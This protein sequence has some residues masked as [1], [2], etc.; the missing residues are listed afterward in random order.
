MNNLYFTY[1]FVFSSQQNDEHQALVK[2]PHQRHRENWPAG[3]GILSP[4]APKQ[5]HRLSVDAN[6]QIPKELTSASKRELLKKV[7]LMNLSS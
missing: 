4:R 7:I 1:I 6:L 2:S 3:K 5:Q